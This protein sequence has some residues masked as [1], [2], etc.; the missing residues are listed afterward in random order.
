[1][2]R[3][4]IEILLIEQNVLL[5]YYTFYTTILKYI[6]V[7]IY[8]YQK[9]IVNILYIELTSLFCSLSKAVIS[10]T[11]LKGISLSNLSVTIRN[12]V[13]VKNPNPPPKK[14]KSANS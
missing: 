6:M 5:N 10:V 13:W 14:K 3:C 2:V 9:V 12:E 8:L 1:M 11:S 4:R 7:W